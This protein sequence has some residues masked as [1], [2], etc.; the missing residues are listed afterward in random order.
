MQEIIDEPGSSMEK[1]SPT[2]ILIANPTAGSYV[3]HAHQIT[4]ILATLQ[5]QG[6]QAEL[7]LTQ[8]SGDARRLTRVAVQ[9]HIDIVVAIGGDGTIHEII[10]ELAGSETALG[11]LP[12]GTV[13]VWAREAG[14][15]L[16]LHGA[17]DVLLNG[18]IRSIDLGKIND[19]YF[20]LMVGI[21][22]DGEVTQS[23]EKRPVKH[24]GVLGYLLV[25]AWW[26]ARYPA[27]HTTI[28]M[29]QQS[30]KANALQ[31]IIGNTQLYGGALKYT[32]LAKCD[33]GLLD[34]CV[35]R[36][37]SLFRRVAV[38][39]DFLLRHPRRTQW[40]RSGTSDTIKLY[41]NY[42]IAIQID[43]EPMGHTSTNEHPTIISVVPRALKV[44]VPTRL[45][46]DLFSQASH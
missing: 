22:L 46:P 29:G 12:G 20:L 41:T 9:Q 1:Q 15:P 2:A 28:E 44:V 35:I 31:V 6:W 34:V 18:Q 13:N 43:G 17:C 3:F 27:F 21:G 4:N 14:I 7:K 19:H 42:P 30:I 5:K 24:L 36:K 45:A 10:Q 32:W 11:V 23:V 8:A 39:V 37:Q 25:A 33:D 26:G 38:I 16:D 40:I